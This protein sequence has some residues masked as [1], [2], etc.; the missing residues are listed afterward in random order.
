MLT[1]TQPNHQTIAEDDYDTSISSN[2]DTCS[3]SNC[4]HITCCEIE[5]CDEEVF[6][7]THCPK[8][9][10]GGSTDIIEEPQIEYKRKR[11]DQLPGNV[12]LRII[13]NCRV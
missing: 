8:E 9:A 3:Q 4:Q 1:L 5:S 12:R 13:F 10:R 6:A 7:L 11:L 2:V